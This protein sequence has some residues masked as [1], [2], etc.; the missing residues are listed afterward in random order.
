MELTNFYA[1]CLRNRSARWALSQA[2][3]VRFFDF[4]QVHEWVDSSAAAAFDEVVV[5]FDSSVHEVALQFG[6]LVDWRRAE[7]G[8]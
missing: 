6:A 1:A 4:A 2:A 7:G 5:D 3:G 8:V